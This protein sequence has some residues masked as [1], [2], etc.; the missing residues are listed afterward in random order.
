M[1][2]I[3]LCYD[4]A[5]KHISDA[6]TIW[7]EIENGYGVP[8]HYMKFVGALSQA[9]DHLLEKH[10]DLSVA[11]REARKEWFDSKVLGGTFRPPFEDWAMRVWELIAV[12][13]A[14]SVMK[15]V[16]D[17]KESVEPSA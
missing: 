10:P 15:E 16:E 6:A 3:Q 7:N 13:A 1:P 4:C 14:T 11:I 2:S 5:F 12:N 17:G 9:A 8:D